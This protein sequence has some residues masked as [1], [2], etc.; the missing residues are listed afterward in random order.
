L[1]IGF[2]AETEALETYA[3]RKRTGK[4]A[5]WIVANN[6]GGTGIMGGP[7]NEIVLITAE[8]SETWPKMSKTSLAEKLAARIAAL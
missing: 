5:D 3:A 1:V 7:D 4:N 6:V 2:A 8:G